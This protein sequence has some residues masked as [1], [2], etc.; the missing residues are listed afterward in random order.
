LNSQHRAYLK[1]TPEDVKLQ[2]TASSG[3]LFPLISTIIQEVSPMA[4]SFITRSS[5]ATTELEWGSMG[6]LSNPTVTGASL[7]TVMEVILAPGMG[8]DFHKHPEQ[9]EVITVVEGRIE[10]WL[11]KQP[12][13]L[14]PGEA[15]FIPADMVHA[16]FNTGDAPAKLLVVLAPCIGDSGY[17]VVEVADQAPWNALR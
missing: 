8:H 11:E 6:F 10:Q 7:L 2:C 15:V 14:G 3:D 13:Q 16:S 9:E 4:G 17:A 5:I 12:Q 1:Q